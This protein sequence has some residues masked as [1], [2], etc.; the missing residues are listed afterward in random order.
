[1][2]S[3]PEITA[4]SQDSP[5]GTWRDVVIPGHLDLAELVSLAEKSKASREREYLACFFGRADKVRGPHPWVGGPNTRKKILSWSEEADVLI[6]EF[7]DLE[8]MHVAMGSA[9]F[10]FIPRGKSGWSLRFFESLFTGCV[11]VMISDLWELP[12]EE[13]L[14][15]SK[16][17]IKWPAEKM[18]SLLQFLRS[19]PDAVIEEYR[20]EAER[21]R[22]WYHYPPKKIDIRQHL[23]QESSLCPDE[24]QNAFEGILRTLGK[25]HKSSPVSYNSEMRQLWIE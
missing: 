12:F 9:K 5:F 13:W 1:M 2:R 8:K 17:V 20:R 4:S 7:T 21:I 25:K 15:V 10:C 24:K 11:P 3:G 22:C 6:S 19:I 16:F 23:L 18:D 14:D